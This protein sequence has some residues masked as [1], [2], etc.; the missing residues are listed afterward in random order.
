MPESQKPIDL[1]LQ[2]CFRD[3]GPKW[4][5][6][7]ET[8]GSAYSRLCRASIPG[9]DL[10]FESNVSHVTAADGSITIDDELILLELGQ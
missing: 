3:L 1:P 9:T 8:T 7:Q 10:Y 6:A 5:L 2:A 4:N